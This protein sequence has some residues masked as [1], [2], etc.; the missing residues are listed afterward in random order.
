MTKNHAVFYQ[1]QFAP[2]LNQP[3][4]LQELI[5][6]RQVLNPHFLLHDELLD[7]PRPRPQGMGFGFNKNVAAKPAALTV[8][9]T[10]NAI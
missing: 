4:L 6:D 9:Q 10:R 1:C 2:V 5:R 3:F 7:D 8:A